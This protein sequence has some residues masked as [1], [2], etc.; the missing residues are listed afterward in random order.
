MNKRVIIFGTRP[1][2]LKLL[3]VIVEIR[4]QNSWD[5]YCYIYTGQHPDLVEDLFELFDFSP[6]F[7]LKLKKP[8]KSLS[9]SFSRILS[10]LQEVIDGIK[11]DFKISFIL[12][13]G[14]T[15]SVKTS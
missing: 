3:P 4:Q 1:E 14:D 8:C 5:D 13:Q 12:G 2:F 7:A 10:G 15:T 11:K 9:N 6:S